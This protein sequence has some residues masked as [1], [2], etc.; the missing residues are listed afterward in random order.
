M[1][2][3]D[4]ERIKAYIDNVEQALKS[5][6][7]SG[8]KDNEK[9]IIELVKDYLHD[10][11]YYLEKEDLFTSLA[12]IAYA[13]GL[14]DCLKRLGII[15]FEWKSLSELMARPKVVVGGTFEIIHP[16]HIYFLKRA[17]EYGRVYVIIARDVNVEKFK[18]RKTYIPEENR[19]KVVSSIKY[20]HKAILGDEKDILKPIEE[21]KPQIIVLGPDQKLNEEE[22]KEK[23]NERGLNVK[24]IRIKD[25]LKCTLCSTSKIV[26]KIKGEASS[27][28]HTLIMLMLLLVVL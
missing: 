24:I 13:E 10:S 7:T 16:G 28:Y 5:I 12:C 18:G 15:N 22:L 9:H 4:T 2:T 1:K 26:E 20:V 14:L 25:R 3:K 6:D 27:F 11:K 19:L 23:L 21:I 17:S 8:L